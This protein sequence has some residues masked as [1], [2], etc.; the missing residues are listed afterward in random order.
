MRA[1]SWFSK[2]RDRM[3][4]PVAI[5]LAV[6]QRTPAER[7]AAAAAE[8]VVKSP[9]GDLL[10]AVVATLATLGA[11]DSLAGASTVS[12]AVL[13][14][15][16]ALPANLTVGQSWTMEVTVTGVGVTYAKSWDV[17]NTLPHGI[18]VQGATLVGNLWVINDATATSGVLTITGAPTA[19]GTFNF[20]VDAWQNTN[21]SGSVT[22]GG[23]TIY[24]TGVAET[25]PAITVQ[26]ASQTVTAGAGVIL[27]ISAS[28]S[29]TL[30]YQWF[31]NG[32]AITG[33]TGATFAIAS[34]QP[35][36]SGS[37][38]VAVTN[39]VSTVTS[40]AATLVVNPAFTRPAFTVQPSSFTLS[41]GSTVLLAAAATGVPSPSYQ[42]Y[43]NNAP[44]AGATG[45]RLLLSGAS[46]TSGGSYTCVATNSAGTATSIPAIVTF[47][48]TADIGRLGNISCRASVGTGG[49]ILIAGY[50]VG[51][52]GT[53]GAENLLVRA[54]GPALTQLGV[55]GT[56]PDPQLQLYSG[57]TVLGT[58]N[59]WLGDSA[60]TAA[61]TALGAFTWPST[62][63]H[64]SAFLRSLAPG[65]Y[66]ALVSGQSGDTGVSLVEVYDD[67]PSG[68]FT[69]TTP[70]LTNISARVSVQTGGNIL[71]AGFVIAGSTARTVLIRASGPA[72]IPLGVTGTLAD[73]LLQLYSGSTLLSSNSGWQGDPQIAASAALVGAFTWA[74]PT[75][76]DAAI[77][78]TLPPGAYT[79]L[80]SG[81][82]GDTG[83]ALVEVYEIP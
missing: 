26:P 66:T 77:L 45:P 81:A 51:G 58:N 46:S 7:V 16:V 53:S 75:S 21:L 63:S 41:S 11:A 54:S 55:T 9:A 60:V 30:T 79:A 65:S 70:R 31:K 15:N 62:T 20:T 72:L 71:I 59:G 69:L 29:P 17:S 36:D 8:A 34:A 6:L 2:R 48:P 49:N 24:V 64:D 82:S 32:T 74:S 14:S 19:P 61:A 13:I 43:L 12:T 42:W 3:R 78:V 83:V 56:L 10:K 38:T 57:S 22:S 44:V 40:Q 80:V 18:I 73:P 76:A 33:A 35:T 67:T 5:L 68:A 52:E 50:T 1:S 25:A 28:G 47:T 27:G 4:A 37:Y 23:T 39:A